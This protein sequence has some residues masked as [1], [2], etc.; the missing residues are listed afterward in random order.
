MFRGQM[1]GITEY[2]FPK[3]FPSYLVGTRGYA[4]KPLERP[5]PRPKIIRRGPSPPDDVDTTCFERI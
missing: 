1:A 5:R 3:I 4:R 2:G